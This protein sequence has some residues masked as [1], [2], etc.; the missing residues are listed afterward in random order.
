MSGGVVFYVL[1]ENVLILLKVDKQIRISPPQVVNQVLKSMQLHP[2]D[3]VANMFGLLLQ[4][5]LAYVLLAP[6]P[7]LALLEC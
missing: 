3:K 5:T 1:A 2:A 7:W 6:M 4:V